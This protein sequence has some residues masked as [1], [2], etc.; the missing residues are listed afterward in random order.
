MIVG[1]NSAKQP[2]IVGFNFNTST[3][4]FFFTLAI[5]VTQLTLVS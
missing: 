4:V 3:I 1:L 5:K 2:V